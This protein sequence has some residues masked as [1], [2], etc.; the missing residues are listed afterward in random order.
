MV[1]RIEYMYRPLRSCGQISGRFAIAY[2]RMHLHYVLPAGRPIV[3][4]ER[5]RVSTPSAAGVATLVRAP[6]RFAKIIFL[7]PKDVFWKGELSDSGNLTKGRTFTETRLPRHDSRLSH[8]AALYSDVIFFFPEIPSRQNS[9]WNSEEYCTHGY[10]KFTRV[11]IPY[12]A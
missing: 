2:K 9:I 11:L 12:F 8:T 7:R 6:P 4:A 3:A 1:Y 5:N 10:S